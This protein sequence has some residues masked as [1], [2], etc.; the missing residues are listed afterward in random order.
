[1]PKVSDEH[2]TRR[3]EEI[4]EAARRCFARHGYEGATVARLEQESGLSRGAIFNYFGSKEEIFVAL[5]ERDQERL[6][7]I[8]AEEGYAAALRDISAEEPAWLGVYIEATRRMRT[9]PEF[10]KRR[11]EAGSAVRGVV[12]EWLERARASGEIRDDLPAE[13]IGTFLGVVVDGLA[14][15]AAAGLEL[16]DIDAVLRLVE[17]ATGGAASR[18]R[19]RRAS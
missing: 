6:G 13:T 17:D 16:P 4:L 18:T 1:V 14:V 3:R 7:R 9:D 12:Q 11:R 10:A 19:V 5:V 8:W 2:R 15:R